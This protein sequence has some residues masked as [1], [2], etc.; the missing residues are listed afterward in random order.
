MSRA[1]VIKT[2]GDQQIAGAIMDGMT[3]AVTPLN[4]QEYARLRAELA[5]LRARDD[6]RA[7][8]DSVRW[9]NVAGALEA[10]YYTRPAKPLTGAI[11]GFYG[12]VCMIV[13]EAYVYFSEWNREA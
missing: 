12:L 11:L 3:R 5:R 1:L 7:Y 13:H 4:E 10:K 6:I 8:G 9:E 2:Y